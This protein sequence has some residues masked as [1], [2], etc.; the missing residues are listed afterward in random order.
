MPTLISDHI[1]VTRRCAICHEK[2]GRMRCESES[3]TLRALICLVCLQRLLTGGI[4][5][6]QLEERYY[7]SELRS[8][9]EA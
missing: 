1:Q 7:A 8:N 9:G 6:T 4:D 2:F 3:G 5:Q